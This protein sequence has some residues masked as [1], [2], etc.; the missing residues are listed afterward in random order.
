MGKAE[1]EAFLSHLAVDRHVAASTQNQ[2]LSAILFLYKA[3]LDRE[4]D[5]IED[6]VQR[7]AQGARAGGVLSADEV[8]AVFGH[9]R[10]PY[11]L[12]AL[13]MYG[14]GLRLRE[15]LRLRVK[16]VGFSYWQITVRDGMGGQGPGDGASRFGAGGAGASDRAGG[17]GVGGR[18][19]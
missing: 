15:C 19:A 13:L 1:V 4:L 12:M 14:G 18:H 7:E 9:L 6:V 10:E 17:C 2:A 8:R 3:V 16:D 11:H 5:W